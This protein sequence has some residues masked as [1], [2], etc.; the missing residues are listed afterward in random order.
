MYESTVRRLDFIRSASLRFYVIACVAV[1]QFLVGQRG[2]TTL[3]YGLIAVA[4]IAIVAGGVAIL[5]GA[6]GDLF[7]DVEGQLGSAANKVATSIP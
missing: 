1:R 5:G 7:S 4:V 2:V 6:F 3:E